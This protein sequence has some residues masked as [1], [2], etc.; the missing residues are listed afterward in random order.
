M[1]TRIVTS[2]LCG[3]MLLAGAAQAVTTIDPSDPN[4]LYTG[5]WS[6]ASPS[7]PWC[8]WIG[9][10]IIANFEGTSI[11]ATFSAGTVVTPDYLRIIVDD[12]PASSTKI[13]VGT[14]TATYTLASD[15][16]HPVHK[17]EI[18]KETDVGDW[19]FYGFELDDGSS[20]SP[21]PA[22]PPRKIEFYGDSNLAGYS[23]ESEENESGQHLRGSYYGYAGIVSRMFNA[24]Y[25]N[26][27]RSGA[28]ISDINGVYDRIA[29]GSATPVWD[30][31][32]FPAD[33]VVVN[34]GANNVGR[35]ENRIKTEYHDFLDDLR[36]VHP[37]AHI[38]LY[39]GWGWDYDEPA[40]YT[41]EVIAERGDPNMSSAIFPWIFEQW[42]GCEYDHAGMAQVL[43]DHLTSV[44]GWAQGPR[45]VMNGF[46]I[47]G[48]VA[49]GSFEEAAPFDG[50]GW[51][52]YTSPGVSRVYAPA[53]AFDGS[54]HLRLAN[55]AASHQPIPADDG[56]VFV[57]TVWMRGA[58]DGDEVDITIDFRDQEMWTAPLQ[59]ATETK[60]VT[61]DWQQYS[62][63]ATA[64]TGTSN[65]VFH[66]RV[67][68]KSAPG[69][70]VDIDGVGM[71]SGAGAVG[72][73]S[74]RAAYRLSA[75]PNPFNPSTSIQFRIPEAGSV[76]LTVY[77]VSGRRVVTLADGYHEGGESAATWNGRD[78]TGREV[79]PGIYF[80][81]MAAGEFTATIKLVLLR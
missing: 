48:D 80:S 34:L 32:G 56:D 65:P 62:M 78:K 60:I 5:R 64:P 44:M 54:Y 55:G 71:C 42:H 35:P 15:L 4:I 13:P 69:D 31:N 20:L 22:R 12:D 26:I 81:R 38:M 66:T 18:I 25:H 51:R 61:S 70:T 28:R 79:G 1:K 52:Y 75:S 50:Y 9:A 68:F 30:F 23:L 27:S 8:Y 3:L 41:H 37:D 17:V 57:L 29:Y 74:L 59:V 14:G 10:S 58:H 6:L 11:A 16:V 33:V 49:N 76:L 21:P 43:A 39:N 53:G 45:D 24:E 2:M 72:S 73:E 36:A 7:Q 47:Y 77:D 67:T 46:G 40:N 19:V 63:T